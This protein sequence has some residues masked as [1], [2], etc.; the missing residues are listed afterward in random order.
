Q[1]GLEAASEAGRL[2]VAGRAAGPALEGA[3]EVVDVVETQVMSDFLV[4]AAFDLIQVERDM[5][6]RQIELFLEVRVVLLQLALERGRTHVEGLGHTVQMQRLPDVPAQVVV[7]R[8][9]KTLLPFERV[10]LR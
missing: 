1:A 5:L 10:H 7:K 6:A 9:E 4:A 2:Q 8:V 3:A